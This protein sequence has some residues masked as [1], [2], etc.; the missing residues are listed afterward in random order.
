MKLFL[1]ILLLCAFFGVAVSCSDTQQA[2]TT[3][4]RDLVE[5]LRYSDQ[6]DNARNGCRTQAKT[7]KAEEKFAE[8]PGYFGGITPKSAYWNE[9]KA[10]YD[11]YY[12]T[13][14]DYLNTAKITGIL[15]ENYS[16]LLSDN[17]LDEVLAF[18]QTRAGKKYREASFGASQKLSELMNK[19]YIDQLK[20]A[21]RQYQDNLND[22]V[23]RYRKNPK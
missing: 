7:V 11:S 4:A 2:R 5:L 23:A 6:V 13:G 12:E 9:I 1:K 8:Y 18:Y 17:E 15:E 22:I 10:L 19:G 21:E 20:E 16:R 3:K 14:C